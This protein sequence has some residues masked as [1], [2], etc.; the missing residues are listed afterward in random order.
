M[1][2]K[3]YDFFFVMEVKFKTYESSPKKRDKKQVVIQKAVYSD[4]KVI[5]LPIKVIIKD[6]FYSVKLSIASPYSTEFI[7][8]EKVDF[9]TI[10][11]KIFA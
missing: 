5:Y 3:T 6:K 9:N 7:N 2:A 11:T 10:M 4:P 1:N 8:V